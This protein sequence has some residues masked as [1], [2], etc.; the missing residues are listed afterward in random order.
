MRFRNAEVE[1]GT[2]LSLY[3]RA[4]SVLFDGGERLV[5]GSTAQEWT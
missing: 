1:N 2:L 5:A 4:G 3:D